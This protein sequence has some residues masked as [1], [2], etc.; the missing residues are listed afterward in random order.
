MP[1]PAP[2][3]PIRKP[4]RWPRFMDW[5]EEVAADKERRAQAG[6]Q[7]ELAR[8]RRHR[9]PLFGEERD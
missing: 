5:R 7:R 6:R 3:K 2:E 9:L 1:E 8:M 4:S